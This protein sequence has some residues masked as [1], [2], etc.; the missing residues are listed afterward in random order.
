MFLAVR[1]EN[2]PFTRKAGMHRCERARSIFGHTS[3]SMTIYAF[4]CNESRALDTI[5]GTSHG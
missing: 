3:V 2:R 1:S 4:G 5:H